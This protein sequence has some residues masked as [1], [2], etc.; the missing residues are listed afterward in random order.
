MAFYATCDTAQLL[1]KQAAYW[2]R[3]SGHFVIGAIC[4]VLWLVNANSRGSDAVRFS[5]RGCNK[6]DLPE[7][8]FYK[9]L[10]TYCNF[11]S[12]HKDLQRK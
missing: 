7:K 6:G 8:G 9:L 1:S 2:Q 12:H 11:H 3:L 10:L 4:Y 5:S